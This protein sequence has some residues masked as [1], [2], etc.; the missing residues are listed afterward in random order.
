MIK[1]DEYILWLARESALISLITIFISIFQMA[2]LFIHRILCSIIFIINIVW[3]FLINFSASS[4][5]LIRFLQNTL[6]PGTSTNFVT[7]G[8]GEIGILL[9][10][11]LG[12]NI[13]RISFLFDQPS[14]YFSLITLC[15]ITLA[16]EKSRKFSLL[17]FIVGFLACPAKISII[18]MPLYILAFI[19]STRRRA[20]QVFSFYLAWIA[21]SI[22]AFSPVLIAV[23]VEV[24]FQGS[25]TLDYSD[26]IASRVYFTWLIG[27]G[28]MPWELSSWQIQ[29]FVYA[30]YDGIA[31]KIPFFLSGLVTL[32]LFRHARPEGLSVITVSLLTLQY[33]SSM[34]MAFFYFVVLSQINRIE[35][36]SCQRYAPKCNLT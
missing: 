10:S 13:N 18:I 2:K 11:V 32:L 14:T 36:P 5:F 35:A 23:I 24:Y 17:F 26:S 15:A 19:S 20:V 27:T 33:G 25:L 7:F 16:F 21:V 9:Q 30:E 28:A 12:I 34:T 29:N 3:L 6:L 1:E 8:P 22:I 4:N 31:A